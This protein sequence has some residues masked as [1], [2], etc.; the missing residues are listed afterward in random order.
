MDGFLSLLRPPIS[1]IGTN[2]V[3]LFSRTHSRSRIISILDQVTVCLVVI[4]LNKMLLHNVM[5][6]Y[7]LKVIGCKAI[8]DFGDAIA[9][10]TMQQN[11]VIV[12]N[13]E[14]KKVVKKIMY[15]MYPKSSN[16][17]KQRDPL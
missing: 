12:S 15:P 8:Q 7:L 10:K 9:K 3:T 11:C 1:Q 5:L 6:M 2:S 13:F 17:D 16:Y 14:M 4:E